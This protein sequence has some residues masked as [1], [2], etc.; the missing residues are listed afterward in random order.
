MMANTKA[1]VATFFRKAFKIDGEHFTEATEAAMT[2][3]A[4]KI[5]VVA[6]WSV[7]IFVVVTIYLL[8]FGESRYIAGDVP[9]VW[10]IGY[11]WKHLLNDFLFHIFGN[12]SEGAFGR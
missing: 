3:L 5:L 1:Q 12:E 6:K 9:L 10:R 11:E 4:D 8:V 2:E 7:K